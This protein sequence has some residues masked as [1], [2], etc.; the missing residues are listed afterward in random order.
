MNPQTNGLKP[1]NHKLVMFMPWSYVEKF[2]MNSLSVAILIWP[3]MCLKTPQN[4]FSSL[5]LKSE[6]LQPIMND[7]Y[8]RKWSKLC[9]SF[10]KKSSA[11][12]MNH[13]G[14]NVLQCP[15]TS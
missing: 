3:I 5:S 15:K 12:G 13:E 10:G 2:G 6:S 8:A 9:L 7:W 11:T 1:I 4:L 14:Q